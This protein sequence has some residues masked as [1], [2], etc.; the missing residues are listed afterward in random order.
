MSNLAVLSL[1]NRALIALV[2]IVAAVFGGLALT[3]LKQELDPVDRVPAARRRHDLPRRLARGRQQRRVRRRSRPRSRASPGSSRRSATSTTNASII[4]ASFTY[5]TDLATAEQKITQAINRIKSQLPDGVEPKVI[6]RSASTTSRSS[7]SPSPATTTRRRS[8]RSSR[9]RVI[10]E[11]EDVDGVNAAADRRR[12]RPARHDHARPRGSSPRPGYTQQAIR[13]ALEQ[14]GVLFPGGDDHRGRPDPHRADRLEDHVGRRHRRAPARA[15][16]GRAVPGRRASRSRMSRPSSRTGPGHDD[17]ARQRRA[18]AHDRGHEAPRG[19]HRRRVDGRARGAARPR[20]RR[21][22]A[23]TFTVV[24]DQAPVHP[25]V[26]RVARDEGLLGLLLRGDRHPDLPAVGARDPRHRDLDPDERADHLHRHP[27]VRLLA[28]HPHPRRAHDRD[29]P[30]GRRLHRRHREHQA[31]L[32]RRCR[33]DA[34]RS[35]APCARSRGAITASTITTVAVFLPIAFVGD[36]TGELFRP[37]ALTVTI[38]LAASL[39]VALTIVPGARVLVPRAR[40]S[41]C[42]TRAGSRDRPRGI[43]TPRRAAC[44]RATC[45]SSRWTLKHSVDHARTRR[46]RARRHDRR[47]R[48]S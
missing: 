32:R 22:A 4:Q 30:R 16:H 42:S 3:S 48:R 24:F 36:I 13:D 9:H 38:A 15:V 29:R 11:L 45:R 17:L 39:L 19:Q 28:E 44:S 41:R 14:N 20:G 35:C 1:K 5:G 25:A 10:P 46:A 47:S 6:S 23:P 12:R 8:R 27:G 26:D 37:F 18:G 21:S 33:Q 43:P 2:T 40:A 7:R 31:A 34:S